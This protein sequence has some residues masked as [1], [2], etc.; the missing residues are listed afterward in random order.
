MDVGGVE[1]MVTMRGE[2]VSNGGDNGVA[3][4]GAGGGVSGSDSTSTVLQG[5]ECHSNGTNGDTQWKIL[6]QDASKMSKIREIVENSA[7]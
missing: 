1:E 2:G 7:R 5:L 4:N 6:S 3:S